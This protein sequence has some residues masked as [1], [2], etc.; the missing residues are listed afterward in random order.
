[1]HETE[2]YTFEVDSTPERGDSGTKTKYCCGPGSHR[3]LG[4]NRE[5]EYQSSERIYMAFHP[6]SRSQGTTYM[7]SSSLRLSV[8]TSLASDNGSQESSPQLR[9]TRLPQGRPYPK[10]FTIKARVHRLPQ[11]PILRARR[12]DISRCREYC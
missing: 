10:S 11:V 9:D 12:P 2:A 8:R 6:S 3:M 5:W 1:M 7:A 4:S